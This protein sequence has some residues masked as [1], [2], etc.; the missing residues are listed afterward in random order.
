MNSVQENYNIFYDVDDLGNWRFTDPRQLSKEQAKQLQRELGVKDDG[1][2]GKDTITALQRRLGVDA[3]GKWG[4][5]STRAW[6]DEYN[7][8]AQERD[9][10]NIAKAQGKVN[11]A[12]VDIFAQEESSK[13]IMEE[14][15][16]E[17]EDDTQ[18][19]KLP[20]IEVDN[21][22]LAYLNKE[23]DKVKK[24][25]EDR[26]ANYESVPTPKTQVGWA[27]YIANN[28]RGLLDK[29]Q[30]AERA[31]YNKLK[32]QEHAKA[33]ANAQRQEQHA[34]NLN[35]ARDTLAKLQIMKDN[36][37]QQGHDTRDI[38]VQIASVY[39]D[40]PEL[41]SKE[42]VSIKEYDP[43]NRV[44][45]VLADIEDID[46]NNTQEEIQEAIKKVSKY[47]T[48]ESIRALNKLDKALIK[49]QKKEESQEKYKSEVDAWTNGGNISN[50]L[51]N[52]G[53]EIQ[54]A[55]D[56]ERLVNKKT[57]K[58]ISERP[59]KKKGTTPSTPSNNS[60]EI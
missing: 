54:L 18:T 34:I 2:V 59:I 22:E 33:L 3:D 17:Q 23:I 7:D 9:F 6:I 41:A 57:G 45:Y 27:S 55:G 46:D 42:D 50:Y 52:L 25:L 4:K 16:E 20:N 30:D 12:I 36:A 29:Y 40:Y 49:R 58:I 19:T 35:D 51:S 1:I 26:Q 44:E 48:P 28:D 31:W 10:H 21:V 47:N 32:D 60:W 8:E 38:D 53:L 14:V 56:K 11:P 5:Q 13:P 43:R 39:R 15:R 24:Q 37:V